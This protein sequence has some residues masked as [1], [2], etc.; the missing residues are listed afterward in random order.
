MELNQLKVFYAVVEN[1]S[2]SKASEALFLSQPTVSFQISSLEQELGTRLL[3]RQGREVTITRSG[4]VLYRY[5]CKILQLS[6]E[7]RQAIEQLKGLIKGELA[8]GA[9]TIP[10]EYILPGLLAEFKGRYPGIDINLVIGDTKGI[11][12]KI[13]DNEVELGVVG[14][15]EKSDKL[16]FDS[17][18]T[19]KLV[20]IAPVNCNWFKH[21]E[22]TVEELKKA[23]FVL[24]E[25]GSGTRATIKQ[26]LHDAGAKEEDFNIVM[27]LGST[28]AVK[29]AVESGAGVS[30]ISEKAIEN[31][32]KLGSIKKIPVKDLELDREFFIVYKRQRSHS[33]AIKAFL[34]FLEEKKGYA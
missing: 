26:K 9:S 6:D 31:E 1:K 18:T 34:Q 27:R 16:V 8:V 5:A 28:A 30:L 13:I 29:R 23:P 4:E 10:G 2:F 21:K 3:D 33:P 15:R 32:I 25:K 19:E 12:K 22:V 24:R 14:T 20:L 17:F 7:A 11:I